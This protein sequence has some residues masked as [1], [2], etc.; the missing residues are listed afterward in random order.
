MSVRSSQLGPAREL[1]G[2]GWDRD[3]VVRVLGGVGMGMGEDGGGR[4]G[5]ATEAWR[6]GCSEIPLHKIHT[7]T[8]QLNSFSYIENLFL[9]ILNPI[10]SSD[11][12]DDCIL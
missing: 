10:C 3:W 7:A 11:S 9:P 12:R 4:L 2:W 1:K 8:K 6:S 5:P